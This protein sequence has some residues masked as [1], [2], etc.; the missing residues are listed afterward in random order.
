MMKCVW[1]EE[2]VSYVVFGFSICCIWISKVY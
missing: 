1:K 2:L